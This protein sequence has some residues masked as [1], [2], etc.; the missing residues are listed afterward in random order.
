MKNSSPFCGKY[1]KPEFKQ[2]LH[3]LPDTSQLSTCHQARHDL[4]LYVG[5]FLMYFEE[6]KNSPLR[7]R[8]FSATRF[9]I[10]RN[11]A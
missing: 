8:N 11:F 3:N 10:F 6:W 1:G 7:V 2:F 4:L 9:S 5:L